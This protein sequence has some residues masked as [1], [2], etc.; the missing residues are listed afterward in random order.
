[1]NGLILLPDDWSTSYYSLSNTNVAGASYTSNTI[2]TTQW[3]TLEQHGAVFLPVTGQRENAYIGSFE[4][5]LYW[6]SSSR[7]FYPYSYS[8]WYGAACMVFGDDGLLSGIQNYGTNRSQG[9]A[10]RL[11]RAAQ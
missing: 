2:T 1:M 9:L 3:A 7:E 4:R 6:T 11:V 8:N 5:G 10:V